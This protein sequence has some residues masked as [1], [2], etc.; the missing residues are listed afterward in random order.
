MSAGGYLTR[1][2]RVWL[3]I[4]SWLV[5]PWV[6]VYRL[7]RARSDALAQGSPNDGDGAQVE[8]LPARLLLHAQVPFLAS[9][10][11]LAV[12]WACAAT[13]P[14]GFH[15]LLGVMAAAGAV[16]AASLLVRRPWADRIALVAQIFVLDQYFRLLMAHT[17]H[18]STYYDLWLLKVDR[19]LFGGWPVAL[20]QARGTAECEAW[21]L[22]YSFFILYLFSSLFMNACGRSRRFAA[23]YFAGLTTLYGVAYLGYVYLPARGPWGVE[24]LY[25]AAL[26]NGP[27]MKTLA[28]SC[29]LTDAFSGAFPSLHVGA[30]TYMLGNDFVFCRDRFW[31]YL[32]LAL[33]IAVSTLTLRM[34]YL[35]DLVVGALLAL[36][37]IRLCVRLAPSSH[38]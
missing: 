7:F 17:S 18:L 31:V 30:M 28:D 34:H 24:G 20:G 25:A 33:S 9:M 15:W 36:L 19:A 2:G 21:A 22:A 8:P 32:P 5:G 38:S 23:A 37:C 3:G 13:R 14:P 35:V 27:W 10:A 4:E 29:K 16:L 26:P 11:A 6:G 1:T 12:A